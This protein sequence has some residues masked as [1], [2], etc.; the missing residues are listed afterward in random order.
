VFQAGIQNL[1]HSDTSAFSLREL[2]TGNLGEFDRILE[3]IAHATP[4]CRAN[5]MYA[6]RALVEMNDD[7]TPDQVL[8]SYAIADTLKQERPDWN[9]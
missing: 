8:M 9:A 6:C 7:A 4:M 3:D 5:V 1:N 2:D